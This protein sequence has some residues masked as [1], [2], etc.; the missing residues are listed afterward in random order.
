MDVRLIALDAD[1]ASD[2]F[3]K[4]ICTEIDPFSASLAFHDQAC[5]VEKDGL[6]FV[7]DLDR[8]GSRNVRNPVRPPRPS[9]ASQYELGRGEV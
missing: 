9:D 6:L 7:P 1:A 3:D 4:G 8:H 2:P 5:P